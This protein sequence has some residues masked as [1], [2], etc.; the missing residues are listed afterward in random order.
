MAREG[1]RVVRSNL[2]WAV[3]YNFAGIAF[4]ATG[5]LHPVLAALLMGV[6]SAIVAAVGSIC[7]MRP[8][9]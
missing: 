2:L 3:L 1:V 4:A 7:V 9:S 8:L 6:S 5:N